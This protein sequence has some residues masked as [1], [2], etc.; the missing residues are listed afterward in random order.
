[1]LTTC[2]E[3]AL[4]AFKKFIRAEPSVMTIAGDAGCGKS[5]LIS[6]MEDYVQEHNNIMLALDMPIIS[7][8]IKCAPTNFAADIIGGKTVH[9]GFNILFRKHSEDRLNPVPWENAQ[10]CL[11]IV[12]ECSMISQHI[13]K[14]ILD[15]AAMSNSHVIFL[16]DLNQL[17]PVKESLSNT[18]RNH[19][20]HKMIT[21]VRQDTQSD[22]YK[23]IQLAKLG[24]NDFNVTLESNNDVKIVDNEEDFKKLL[25]AEFNDKPSNAQL[26]VY[27]NA[28]AN[29]YKSLNH[30]EK[31]VYY[32]NQP[33]GTNLT[34]FGKEYS[35]FP[36]TTIHKAQGRTYHT[37][38]IDYR[39]ILTS[40]E[41]RRLFYVALSR[42]SH[43]AV[44]LV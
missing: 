15:R 8:V 4:K 16:G 36:V 31:F 33:V 32:G 10:N 35:K 24:I 41:H 3:S 29:E 38:Y 21:V 18:F 7:E 44:I 5:M 2:Q 37:V 30:D 42:A 23:S 20:F 39:D 14:L 22:L 9:K 17:F 19:S 6:E 34:G 26:L 27:S 12:D 28:K 1:M 11:Y 13:Y 25:V 43:K 40:R